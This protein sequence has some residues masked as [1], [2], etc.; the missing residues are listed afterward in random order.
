MRPTPA[1]NWKPV[2]VAQGD[3][4][5]D[6]TELDSSTSMN[7]CPLPLGVA[8]YHGLGGKF[9]ER[10]LP[11]SE[12]DPVALLLQFLVA[13]GN[14]IGRSAYAVAGGARHALNLYV[15]IVGHT[16][17]SRKGTS[18]AHV[19]RLF[20]SVDEV[21][22]R[23]HI[24][25]SVSSGEGLIWRVRDPIFQTVKGESH[26]IDDGV[27]DK[28]LCVV[29]TELGEILTLM[30]RQGN[31]LSAVLRNAWDDGNLSTV[32]KNSPARA[33]S[34]LVSVVGHV[35]RDEVR[36]LLSVTE[37][38]N[39]FG[40]RFLWLLVKRSKCL[41]EGGDLP[42]LADI[43]TEL[44][45]TIEFARN[46]DK[47]VRTAS[48]RELWE[49]VYP[50]LS[51][52]KPGLV[53]ALTARAEA[54]TLRLSCIY[55]LLDCSPVVDVA[56]LQAALELWRYC[57]AST[58]LIFESGTGDRHADRILQALKVA[59]KTGLTKT[60]ISYNVFNRNV[61]RF[62]LDEALRLIHRLELGYRTEERTTGGRAVERWT[63]KTT[64]E[65]S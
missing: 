28:R 20:A 60:E 49:Q 55:A 22:T 35:T 24:I 26:V 15:A 9:V 25:R 23:D 63:I 12:A 21:W 52:G 40:N 7:D 18:W 4:P 46:T 50:E 31:T 27:T 53:G 30:S 14:L 44:R 41:P 62:E 61:T 57:E 33:T 13:F 56:H 47:I 11:E 34:A 2:V 10:V 48:A 19:Q 42:P 17:K 54:Q 32:T 8:A 45:R 6:L 59:G 36:K 3:D 37:S 58:C 65:L 29:A 43:V 16:S 38:A 39:G 64:T 1:V 51:E 5:S